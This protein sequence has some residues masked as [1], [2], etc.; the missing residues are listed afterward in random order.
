MAAPVASVTPNDYQH[1]TAS[2]SQWGDYEE[3]SFSHN[4]LEVREI[5]TDFERD[6]QISVQDTH[7]PDSVHICIPLSGYISANFHSCQLFTEMEPKRHQHFYIPA[8]EYDC[9]MSKKLRLV[10]IEIEKDYF[11]GLLSDA[12]QWS[13]S[14]R[15][16]LLRKEKLQGQRGI[17]C[18]TM[19]QIIHDILYTPLTGQLRNLLIEAKVLELIALQLF[20]SKTGEAAVTC[21]LKKK[22]KEI[23][24]AIHEYLTK[25]FS[26]EHSLKGLAKTYGLNEFSLKKGFKSLYGKTVFDFLFELRM[27]HARRM[28]VEEGKLI[29]EVSREI[30]YK[31]PNHFSTAF[32]KK[33]G[34]NPIALRQ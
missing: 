8:T 21:C 22:D 28:L 3:R 26:E 25:N 16:K 7:L 11:T 24:A 20:H 9:V 15:E 29:C 31:N 12:E 19:Q 14:I 6:C 32:K 30:G 27:N 17:V 34:M 23:L 4:R 1:W 33:F 2:S 18:T 13:A 5:T 10:D